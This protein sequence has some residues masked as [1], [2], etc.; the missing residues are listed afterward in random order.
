M[1]KVRVYYK[2]RM[3]CDEYVWNTEPY[4]LP[5]AKQVASN[6]SCMGCYDIE[7]REDKEAA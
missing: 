4:D 6:L 7:L 1:K 5:K 3:D 2:D